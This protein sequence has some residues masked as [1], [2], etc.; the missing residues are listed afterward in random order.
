MTSLTKEIPPRSDDIKVVTLGCRLNTYESEVMKGLAKD[1]GMSQV[2][3]I[4]TCAVTGNAERQSRQAVRRAKKENPN[5]AIFVTGCSVQ[6]NPEVYEKMPG[7]TRILGNHDKLQAASFAKEQTEK[8]LVTDIAEVTET[9]HHLIQG[10][11]HHAR[12][13][14]QIQNGC[15]HRCTFCT[16]PHAR[17]PNRSVPV[18]EI[19]RQIQ[20]LVDQGCQEVVF[21]GVDITDYGGDLPGAPRL[22]SLVR[23]VLNNVPGLPRLRLS[24]LD[25][26]EV[27]EELFELFAHPRLMPH[28]HVSLQ[29][30]DDMILKRM[31]RRHL[32]GDAISFCARAKE[33]RPDVVL[34]ADLIAGFPTET[35]EMFQNTLACIEACD[36][37]YLHIFPFSPR[38]GT[39]A[40]RM[41]Q[42]P[43]ALIQERAKVMREVGEARLAA[44]LKT[45]E[46]RFCKVL[47]EEGARGH[48]EHYAPVFFTDP[49]EVAGL[50]GK[51]VD[52]QVVKSHAKALEVVKVARE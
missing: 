27:D 31:K 14:L 51:I 29:A 52:V 36:L 23:R 5:A 4:N 8:V 42:L 49:E 1:A 20:T 17:G 2:V 47:V 37:T 44:F 12:A 7:V 45:Q 10:F 21:T 25:P 35:D 19:V 46:G 38:P 16:I 30:G 48:T 33:I 50:V 18:A 24:S 39:P 41:P 9:A 32:R 6:L 11:D 40:A 13:F 3:I 43:S 34:G 26:S 15:N 22:G 28:L